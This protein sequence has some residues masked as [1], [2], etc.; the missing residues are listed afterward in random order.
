MMAWEKRRYNVAVSA[1]FGK[2]DLVAVD[3]IVCGNFGI[4][5]RDNLENARSKAWA[6]IHLPTGYA[7]AFVKGPVTNAKRIA[8]EFEKAANWDFR[9]PTPPQRVRAAARY[10][11]GRHKD[12]LLSSMAI[13]RMRRAFIYPEEQPA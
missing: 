4:D 9:D 7:A 3:G 13:G 6:V 2:S 10:V 11:L 1:G 12:V 5:E 8:A